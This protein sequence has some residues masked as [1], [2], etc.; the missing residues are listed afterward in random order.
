M[1][2]V[3]TKIFG[4]KYDRDVKTYSPVVE[5]INELYEEYKNLSNEELRNKTLEFRERIAAHLADL[6]QEI[7]AL[8]LEA[9][10]DADFSVKESLYRELDEAT[11]ER[12]KSL[13]VVLKT[14][15]PEAFAVVKETCRRFFENEIITTT[16]TEHDRELAANKSYVTIEGDK[17]LW[18]NEWTAAGANIKWNMIPYDVQLIGGMVLHDGKIAEMS[19]GEGKTLVATMPSYLNALAG[20]GVH[21]V[22]VNDYLARRDSEWTAPIHEFLMLKVDCIDK[23]QPHSAARKKAYQSDITIRIKP[24]PTI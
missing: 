16:A 3:F 1:F 14:I 24:I 13:E 8:R 20:L 15:L 4:S 23:H 11:K 9:E 22:T 12:D 2:K 18:K 10:E 19:T 7:E 17:A 6:D 21:I 5:E